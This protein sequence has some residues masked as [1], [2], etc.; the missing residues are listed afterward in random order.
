MIPP[1]FLA[2]LRLSTPM[3]T[4]VGRRVKLSR[5]GH[6]HKG[7]CPFHAEQTPSFYV[8][9]APEPHA[10]CFGCGWHGDAVAYLMALHRM[11]FT[12]A[13]AQLAADAGLTVPV[14]EVTAAAEAAVAGLRDVLSGAAIE[15][16]KRLHGPKGADAM[17]YLL[18]RGL[19]RETIDAY[20]IGW[21]DRYPLANVDVKSAVAAGLIWTSD[22][23]RQGPFFLNRI[24]FP[25]R[26]RHGR[27]VGFSGRAID[28]RKPKYQ[29][30]PETPLFKKSDILHG[31]DF[32]AKAARAGATV[33]VV[34][35]QI[36]ML[37]AHQAGHL[38][39]VALLGSAL[40][41]AH[42]REL[43]RMSPSPVLCFDG[44]TAGRHAARRAIEAALPLLTA[45]Q[46]LRVAW[47]PDGLDPD[48]L[49][50][51]DPAAYAA[52]IAAPEGLPAALY[53]ML[54]AEAD[55]TTPEGRAGLLNALVTA[56]GRVRDPAM[57]GEYRRELRDQ[58]YAARRPA[59]VADRHLVTGVD[60][61]AER[62]RTLLA[63]LVRHPEIIEDAALA[64]V[65]LPAD[66][67]LATLRDVLL[68]AHTEHAED[69][70]AFIRAAGVQP[71]ADSVLADRPEPANGAE[72]I[73]ARWW[74]A[75]GPLVSGRM[76][77]QIDEA[78]AAF[79]A[80]ST[81]EAQR[82]LIALCEARFAAIRDTAG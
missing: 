12:E 53:G 33:T 11:P 47:L 30:S 75:Y 18:G 61:T 74:S 32:A 20:Q 71:I 28:D 52:C 21:S 81:P 2:E 22:Q 73:L 38:G 25:L 44:D 17:A 68:A 10:H 36:D 80:S 16:R 48:T 14:D 9:D 79:Q 46:V 57:A 5:A 54:H 58:F 41:E 35:G 31:V 15:Y 63:M 7:C 26:D 6:D 49:I 19:T 78:K 67:A 13:V 8:Y 64:I 82:R 40:S 76:D 65:D 27:V 56:S 43:W 59:L 34:E 50:R 66:G 42:L 29:N 39:T 45:T 69:V 72:N 3:S 70:A 77:K 37:Q 24:M 55:T 60:P 4:L 23:G 1:E 51:R 62:T